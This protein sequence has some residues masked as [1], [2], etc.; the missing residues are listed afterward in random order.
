MVRRVPS[1]ESRVLISEKVPRSHR[2]AEEPPGFRLA[3]VCDRGTSHN[4]SGRRMVG[5]SDCTFSVRAPLSHIITNFV[6]NADEQTETWSDV[7]EKLSQAVSMY[8]K[9]APP[10]DNEINYP[11]VSWLY[12]R[13]VLRHTALVFSIWAAKGWGPLAFTIMLQS[14]LSAVPGM[15]SEESKS[16]TASKRVSYNTLERHTIISGVTR[17][18]ITSILA[19]AHGPWLLHLG[20][21]ERILVLENMAAMYSILGYKRKEAYILREVL[22]CVMDLVVC[23]RDE[24]GGARITGAGLGIQGV[25]FGGAPN[26]GT[27]GVRANNSSDGNESVLRVVRH[28]CKVHGIDLEA[29]SLVADATRRVSASPMDDGDDESVAFA[30]PYG[31]PEL[32][33]GIVREAIAVAEALP[34]ERHFSLK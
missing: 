28:V 20:A 12:A 33:I 23:G 30:E 4:T 18:T 16:S 6:Q 19:Q 29:V 1:F 8:G 3:R 13:A 24:N 9:A 17:A 15:L 11:F 25:D 27:V 26:Q 34:G 31:W 7:A 2:N 14:G 32:Q 22:G 5:S 10:M 21:S